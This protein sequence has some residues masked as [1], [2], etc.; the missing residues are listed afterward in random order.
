MTNRLAIHPPIHPACPHKLKTAFKRA[1]YNMHTLA[2]ACGVNIYYASRAIRFGERPTNENV[3]KML[4]FAR[5]YTR[6][7]GQEPKP[8]PPHHITW[9]RRLPKDDRSN[10]I[11]QAWKQLCQSQ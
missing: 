1:G 4:F 9:W 3:A 5:T 7:E 6:R 11:R 10:I 2:R 8:E